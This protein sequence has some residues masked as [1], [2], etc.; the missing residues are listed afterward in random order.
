M[1]IP[2][3]QV[4][5]DKDFSEFD[6]LGASDENPEERGHGKGKNGLDKIPER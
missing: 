6:Y 1:K 2:T 4:E 3:A 5:S